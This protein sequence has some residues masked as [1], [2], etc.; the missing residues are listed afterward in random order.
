MLALALAMT[1]SVAAAQQTVTINLRDGGSVRGVVVVDIPGQPLVVDVGGGRTFEIRRE[2][3]I[4]MNRA[5]EAVVGPSLAPAPAPPAPAAP[6]A[7]APATGR[8][9]LVPDRRGLAIV[10]PSWDPRVVDLVNRR[11]TASLRLRSKPTAPVILM[12]IGLLGMIATP[13]TISRIETSCIEDNFADSSDLD[14]C[15][16]GLS[17]IRIGVTAISA[18]MHLVG[19]GLLVRWIVRRMRARSERRHVDQELLEYDVMPSPQLSATGVTG[20]HL[21][22]RLRF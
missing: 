10:D 19:A 21:S 6:A 9:V 17:E 18:A 5:P 4:S 12:G 15:L 3:I 7:M 11:N 1:P 20:G 14:E 8:V 2:D 13:I 16:S 22:F